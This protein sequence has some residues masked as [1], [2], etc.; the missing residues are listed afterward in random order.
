MELFSCKCYSTSL[1][2]MRG[3]I[4]SGN[5]LVPLDNK[6]I[7]QSMLT[8]IFVAIWSHWSLTPVTNIL[9]K[10]L[11]SLS[12]FYSLFIHLFTVL[13]VFVQVNCVWVTHPFAIICAH[14]K[15]GLIINAKARCKQT[16]RLLPSPSWFFVTQFFVHQIFV[17]VSCLWR[18]FLIISGDKPFRTGMNNPIIL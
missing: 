2:L 3:H 13:L 11:R 12:R 1:M 4:G 16:D 10:Q 15:P 17:P 6:P 18:K 7:P 8:Q 9:S 14:I 5:G